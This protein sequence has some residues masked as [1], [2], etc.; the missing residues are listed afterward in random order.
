MREELDLLAE[1]T[2]RLFSTHCGP[3]VHAAA[4]RGEW[5]GALW[6]QCEDAGL[7]D[8]ASLEAGVLDLEL[9]AAVVRAAARHAAPVPLSET[10]LARMALTAAELKAPVGPLTLGP[11]LPSD[12]PSLVGNGTEWRLAGRMRRIPWARH[13]SAVVALVRD[14]NACR[15]VLIERPPAALEDR[16]YAG[17]PR[18][19]VQADAAGIREEALGLPGVGWDVET[20]LHWG[21]L[22]RAMAMAGTMETVLALTVQHATERIQ[23]GRPIGKFQAVQHQIAVLASHAAAADAAVIGAVTASRS[24]P[25]PFEIAAAKVR[26]GEAAGVVAEIAHQ[27]HGAMGFTRDHS[28]HRYTR[29]LWSWRDEFGSESDWAARIGRMAATVGGEALWQFLTGSPRR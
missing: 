15:T 21:A 8:A 25:A 9:A 3:S 12:H 26:V 24:A 4:D 19:N 16:N 20:L 29:R 14:G 17:E 27:V 18:D 6:Q 5:Q 1:S 11:V 22:F 23:F 2:N 13:A 10:M 28:L 7:H